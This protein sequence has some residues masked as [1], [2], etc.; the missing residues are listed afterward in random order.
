MSCANEPDSPAIIVHLFCF[1]F[2]LMLGQ[3]RN[4]YRKPFP[5]YELSSQTIC[6]K[7]QVNSFHNLNTSSIN[8]K[9]AWSAALF[10]KFKF[11]HI[12]HTSYTILRLYYVIFVLCALNFQ[13]LLPLIIVIKWNSLKFHRWTI[14]YFAKNT[15]THEIVCNKNQW[16]NLDFSLL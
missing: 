4:W 14:D 6:E 13:V 5:I 3:S 12:L 11:T 8:D 1:L 10:R 16:I 9:G 2:E 7:I 15:I